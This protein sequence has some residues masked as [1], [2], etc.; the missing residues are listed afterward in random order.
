MFIALTP[1]SCALQRSAMCF[2]GSVYIPLLT[3]RRKVSN[4][5]L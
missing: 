5:E 3:E 1:N 4:V 2:G